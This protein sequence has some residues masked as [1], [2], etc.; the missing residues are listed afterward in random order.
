M[1]YAIRWFWSSTDSA[2]IFPAIDAEFENP[3]GLRQKFSFLID[4]GADATILNWEV[5]LFSDVD[6]DSLPRLNVSGVGGLV[7]VLVVNTQFWLRRENNARIN[8]PGSFRAFP[9]PN[10]LET[11]ILGR[12]VLNHFAVI[13]DRPGDNVSLLHGNHH[14]TIH[15]R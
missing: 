1:N 14:Y 3:F 11:S 13:V 7:E 12:D 10:D 2:R 8:F 15:Q 9:D 5:L 6:L 4:T